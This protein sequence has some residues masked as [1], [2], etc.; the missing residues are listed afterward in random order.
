MDSLS[1]SFSLSLCLSLSLSLCL[2]P[3]PCL[4]LC[5]CL[6]LSV[7]LCLCL[8][9]SLSLSVSVSVSLSLCLSLSH[10][11]LHCTFFINQRRTLITTL[12][13]LDSK[14]LDCTDYDPTQTLLLGN[15][16]QTL[17][18]KFKLINASIDYIKRFDKPLFYMNS[19]V[20]KSKFNQ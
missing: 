4:Y 9:L 5:L 1:L 7:C 2:S 11:F 17:S 3:P 12:R 13:S 16:S 15:T 8:C 10:F 14:L 19:F 6:C 20:S 18:N